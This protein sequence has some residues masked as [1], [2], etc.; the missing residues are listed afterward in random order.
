LINNISIGGW[1]PTPYAT[2]YSAS[3]FG[4]RGFS[5]SLKGELTEYPNIHVVDL[6]PCFLDTPGIQHAANY[7]GKVV[8]PAPPIADPRTVA[9]EVVRLIQRPRSR[10]MIGLSSGFL[11]LS[12]A[13]FPK[14]TRNITATV[15][16]K[17][18]AQAKLIEHTSGNV[19]KPVDYGTG[20]DGG[21]RLNKPSREATNALI[22][23]GTI[24]LGGMLLGS[25][26]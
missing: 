26:K 7:T 19:L 10:K 15:I 5:E 24:A 25:R 22:I 21:W 18:L 20:I 9:R 12:Y 16:R 2:A 1:F 4:L 8:K 17:Y 11:R 3:K 13:L 23:F 14:L 6:Y